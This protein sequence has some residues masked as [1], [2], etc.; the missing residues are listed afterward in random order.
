M[1]PRHKKRIQTIS[2][3]FALCFLPENE[4]LPYPADEKTVRILNHLTD[5]DKLITKYAPKFPLKKIARADLSILR[6]SIYELVIEKELP[7]K[8]VINEAVELAKE[9]S[10]EHSYAFINAVLGKVLSESEGKTIHEET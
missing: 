10:G 5:I 4:K 9:L 2:N 6:L 7:K 3:L 8:V 1:D